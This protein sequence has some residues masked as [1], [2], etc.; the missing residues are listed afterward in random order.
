[1]FILRIACSMSTLISRLN[2]SNAKFCSYV[3][4]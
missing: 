4:P 3:Y 2:S 1:M